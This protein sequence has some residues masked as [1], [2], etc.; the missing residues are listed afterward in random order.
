[1]TETPP[2]DRSRWAAALDELTRKHEGDL[3]TIELLDSTYGANEEVERLPFTY[4]SY[5]D[6]DDVVIVAVGGRSARHP[7][8]LRHM[9]WHPSEVSVADGAMRV[10]DGEGTATVVTFHPAA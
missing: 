4:A 10:V 8:V 1:M 2:D 6:R 3:V 7:V 5:D 9:V